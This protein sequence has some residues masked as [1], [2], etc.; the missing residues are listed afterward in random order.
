MWH[1]WM[2]M[3]SGTVMHPAMQASHNAE[4]YRFLCLILLLLRRNMTPLD[5]FHDQLR[6]CAVIC[7]RHRAESPFQCKCCGRAACGAGV[8]FALE[9]VD[10]D[11][12][13]HPA[14][15]KS[16]SSKA[17]DTQLKYMLEITVPRM[18]PYRAPLFKWNM[19]PKDHLH[20]NLGPDGYVS[21]EVLN[22]WSPVN[23]LACVLRAIFPNA[24]GLR[25]SA[26]QQRGGMISSRGEQK[27]V[28][29]WT[30]TAHSDRYVRSPYIC[31]ARA[32]VKCRFCK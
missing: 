11:N 32:S 27:T 31:D 25:S 10:A 18:Y 15:G 17:C 23:S 21:V 29:T 6:E 26:V 24:L 8:A 1:H 16:N 3:P 20:P 30:S 12:H 22:S 14:Y 9:Y 7:R 19:Q 28:R 5:M 13:V 2:H 4:E